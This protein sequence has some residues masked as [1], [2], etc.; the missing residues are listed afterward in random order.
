VLLRRE[1][2]D[3]NGAR[4]SRLYKESGLPLRRKPPKRRVKAKLRDGGCAVGDPASIRVDQGIEI[5]SRDRDLSADT[6]NVTLDDAVRNRANRS[7]L[8]GRTQPRR[9]AS[10]RG[11]ALCHSVVLFDRS[12]LSFK[13]RSASLTV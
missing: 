5:I 9:S 7:K 2:W 11:G 4:F 12:I 6:R 8:P 13:S 10:F 3:V 1:G